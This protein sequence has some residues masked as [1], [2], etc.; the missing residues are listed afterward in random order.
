ML[1]QEI[2]QLNNIE[3]YKPLRAIFSGSSQSGKTYLI[4]K[5][6]QKQHQLFGEEFSQVKYFYPEY[7]EE[8][9]V[10]WHDTIRTPISYESGFPSKQDILELSENSLL[11]IDDNMQK[12][13]NSE[14]MRQLFNV[15]SKRIILH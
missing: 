2:K 8:S 14:L 7:L 3:F 10:D 6:L 5:M 1:T 9:P 4:G 15:I 13:V 12:V 11:I